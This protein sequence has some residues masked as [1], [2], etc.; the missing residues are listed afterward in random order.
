MS[1]TKKNK[2]YILPVMLAAL[3][4]MFALNPLLFMNEPIVDASAAIVMDATSG[5]VLYSKNENVPLAPASMSKLM[6][7]YIILEEIERGNVS[8][9]EYVV[10]SETAASTGGA[11]IP[12]MEGE[13]ISVQDLFYA[14]VMPSANN[15][16]VLLAEH[17]A[18]SEEEF[19]KL[20]NEKARS[21]G[22]SDE[23]NFVNATGLPNE[24]SQQS[25]MT[26]HDVASLSIQL[27]DRFPEVLEITQLSN[28]QLSYHN[29]YITTTN[30]M[31][32][33]DNP[34]I[35]FDGLDGLKTGYTGEAGY[36][37]AGTAKQGDKRI[38]SVIMGTST[39]DQRFVETRKLMAY[40][41][42]NAP[43]TLEHIVNT[44]IYKFKTVLESKLI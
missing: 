35:L 29:T 27:L 9:D 22:L 31:L 39:T 40:G 37:F 8:W 23:T 25:T 30:A 21:L 24:I 15:A 19:T 43:V 17:I 14:M 5:D 11:S 12:L 16:T 2:V 6:T 34:K 26:A 28:Y 7:E 44:T 3:F 20:M 10:I 33:S 32:L 18:G 42:E 13:R 1:K 4:S 38:V 41:F 36:C